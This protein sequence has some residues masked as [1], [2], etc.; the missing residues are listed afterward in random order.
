MDDLIACLVKQLSRMR[1][2][3][4]DVV[5]RLH[6]KHARDKTRPSLDEL[7]GASLPFTPG[8]SLQLTRWMSAQLSITRGLSCCHTFPASV[9][10][11]Q[12]VSLRPPGLFQPSRRSLKET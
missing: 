12:S 7:Q 11:L 4:P 2:S 9:P 3:L 5:R 1:P 8:L 10:I 6:K